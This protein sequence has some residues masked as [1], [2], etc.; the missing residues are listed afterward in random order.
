MRSGFITLIGRP[1]AGKSTLL[2]AILGQK[3]SIISSK[4]QTTRNRIL[5]IYTDEHM[6]AVMVDTP[7]VHSAKGRLNQS[8]VQVAT[9]ALAGVDAVCWVL[10]VTRPAGR[11]DK[12][13]PPISPPERGIIDL[14]K[15]SGLETVSVA[16]NKVDL[17]HKPKMLPILVA[18]SEALP[19]ADLVPMSAL[20]KDVGVENLK[21]VWQTSLPE[22][23]ALFPPDQITDVSERFVVSELIREKIFA[24]THQE[25][26]YAVA[27]EVEK[28][29]EEEREGL[30]PLVTIFARILVERDSQ[31]GILIGKGGGR[32]KQV[33]SMARREIAAMLGAKIYLDLHVSV[34]SEW[35]NNPRMLRELGYE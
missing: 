18:L 17:I 31:K 16:L 21:K 34:A 25:I 23:P 7:G 15:Q 3:I 35:T 24:L 28:F 33:G 19:G 27:V 26:P 2:N 20:R 9:D 22:G 8:M 13:K 4:P 6:Q 11:L 32:L 14:I 12:N 29:E 10:D 30:A 5:G 1:N